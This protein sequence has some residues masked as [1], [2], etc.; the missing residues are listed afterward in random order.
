M[1]SKNSTSTWRIFLG[2]WIIVSAL[3]IGTWVTP[4]P[5]S[6]TVYAQ[7]MLQSTLTPQ[8]YLPLVTNNYCSGVGIKCWSGIH[9]G[10]R[11]NSDWNDTIL[12]ALDPIADG[13]WPKATVVL[14]SQIYQIQRYPLTMPQCLAV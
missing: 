2:C 11:S 10:N 3:V 4:R 9:L 6:P 8:A 13:T 1:H 5:A 14:S 7:P 12:Q